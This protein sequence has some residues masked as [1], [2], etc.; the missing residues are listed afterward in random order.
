[1]VEKE[2]ELN[3]HLIGSPGTETT[4]VI[5][6]DE[7]LKVYD[8]TIVTLDGII[9]SPWEFFNKRRPECTF[10]DCHVVFSKKSLS[11]T[12]IVREKDKF[13]TTVTGKLK[14]TDFLSSLKLNQTT[15]YTIKE[16]MEKLKFARMYF[17]HK[18][19]HKK[20]LIK[21]RNFTATVEKTVSEVNDRKTEKGSVIN[22]KIINFTEEN[23]LDFV[24]SVPIFEGQPKVDIP[25]SI[26]ME[27]RNGDVIL[28]LIYD[29]FDEIQEETIEAI[30]KEQKEKFD[31]FAC[32]DKD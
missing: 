22:E 27:P 19:E 14:R 5:R 1:M 26:E 30:F 8:P 20:L 31:D 16:L 11:I 28:F 17:K 3:L 9:T 7:P 12:F 15:G 2:Q 24:L 23:A 21:L 25:I 10:D 29:D 6:H 18:E 32:I 4:H 13:K